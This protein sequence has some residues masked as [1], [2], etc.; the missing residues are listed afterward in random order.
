MLILKIFLQILNTLSVQL[1]NESAVQE[2]LDSIRIA[3]SKSS[4]LNEAVNLV[5][6]SYH[7]SLHSPDKYSIQCIP[8]ITSEA[9]KDLVPKV[10]DITKGGVGVSTKVL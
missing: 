10:A 5:N 9:L 6:H 4:P 3:A 7:L 8:H 1:A 2:K